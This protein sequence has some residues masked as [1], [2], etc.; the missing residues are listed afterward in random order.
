MKTFLIILVITLF[1]FSPLKLNVYTLT[2]TQLSPIQH[3]FIKEKQPRFKLINKKVYKL[4]KRNRF[5]PIEKKIK[6]ISRFFKGKRYRRFCLGEG[7]TGKLD[8]KPLYRFDTF[9]C[10]T[11][12]ETVLAIANSNSYQDFIRNIKQIRYKN[13]KISFYNRKHF[14]GL[15]WLPDNSEKGYIKNSTLSLKNIP[16][17]EGSISVDKKS[18]FKR[19]SNRRLGIK[20]RQYTKSRLSLIQ[21]YYENSKIETLEIKFI[22]FDKIFG[23]EELEKHL[24]SNLP[25]ASI[26]N[27]LKDD[28]QLTGKEITPVK[29]VHQGFFIKKKGRGYFRHA[30][31][32]PWQKIVDI[33][34]RK[35]LRKLYYTHARGITIYTIP[36]KKDSI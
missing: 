27:I 15:E 7:K 26:I 32:K 10:T 5:L 20:R 13:N 11:Y 36:D 18:W 22:D 21:N 9:D 33:P 24:I 25:N 12:I 23:D 31:S 19:L 14:P 30:S 8:K 6:N 2:N 16:I 34:I 28:Y 3:Y 17:S 1:G 4:I 29:I 35:Y